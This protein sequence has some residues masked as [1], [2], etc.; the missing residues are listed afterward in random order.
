MLQLSQ[1]QWLNPG[2]K[3]LNPGWMGYRR[4]LLTLVND[5]LLLGKGGCAVLMGPLHELTPYLES[6]GFNMQENEN[7]ADWSM[8]VVVL[9]RLYPNLGLR[10]ELASRF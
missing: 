6:L 3:W 7:P 8:D 5:M 9:P 4:A 10:A 2:W 1:R